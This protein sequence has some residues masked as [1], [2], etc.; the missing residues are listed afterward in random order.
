MWLFA[1]PRPT[2]PDGAEDV[3]TDLRLNG[4]RTKVQLSVTGQGHL[5]AGVGVISSVSWLSL[6][7]GVAAFTGQITCLPAPVHALPPR[8]RRTVVP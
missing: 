6:G 5:R 4:L 3:A 7:G 2:D 1:L 8:V